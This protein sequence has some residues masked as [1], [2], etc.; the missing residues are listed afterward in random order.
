MTDADF[1]IDYSPL[2]ELLDNKKLIEKLHR[3]SI[4][5]ISKFT[6]NSRSK[7]LINFA[8]VAQLDRAPD[9]GSGG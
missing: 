4:K 2:V 6:W 5:N 9:F 7:K 8:S 1:S 3:L